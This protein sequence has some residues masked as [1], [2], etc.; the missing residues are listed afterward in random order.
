[1]D[2]EVKNPDL[3]KVFETDSRGRINLGKEWAGQKV[4]V[5]IGKIEDNN[6]DD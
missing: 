2:T 4:K 1:M 5:A 6:N 3:V